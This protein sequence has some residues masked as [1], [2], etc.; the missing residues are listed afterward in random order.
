ME[1]YRHINFLK[2]VVVL[3]IPYTDHVG[4]IVRT[5]MTVVVEVSRNVLK[6][7]KNVSELLS[8]NKSRVLLTVESDNLSLRTYRGLSGTYEAVISSRVVDFLSVLNPTLHNVVERREAGVRHPSLLS[9]VVVYSKTDLT[10]YVKFDLLALGSL[11]SV[12]LKK[13]SSFLICTPSVALE[14]VSAVVK[15]SVAIEGTINSCHIY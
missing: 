8:H 15:F 2:C 13:V 9:K 1:D 14:S 4:L 6:L 5:D 10:E 12:E 11:R 3:C 7:N